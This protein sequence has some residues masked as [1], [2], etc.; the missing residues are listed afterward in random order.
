MKSS[1]TLSRKH[2][3][4]I[5]LWKSNSP[6]WKADK[7]IARECFSLMYRCNL[8]RRRNTYYVLCIRC[9]VRTHCSHSVQMQACLQGCSRIIRSIYWRPRPPWCKSNTPDPIDMYVLVSSQLQQ[10]NKQTKNKQAIPRS[11]YWRP[12]RPWC[13]P[14]TPAP[15]CD[16]VFDAKKY[17][18]IF[19]EKNDIN[20]YPNILAAKAI[21][22]QVQHP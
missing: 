22:M 20:E 13:K 12:R 17:D 15:E 21:Q 8:C 10:R 3:Q 18:N 19:V 5:Q 11:T 14:N 16:I 6:F 2:V 1:V 4:K 7:Y 9:T